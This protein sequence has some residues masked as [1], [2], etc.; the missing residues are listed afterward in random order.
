MSFVFLKLQVNGIIQNVLFSLWLF[1]CSILL[2]RFLHAVAF[3]VAIVVKNPSANAGDP[4]DMDLIP[5]SRRS[6]GGGHDKPLQYSCLENPMGRGAW[7]PTVH[8][9]AK[10][11]T[12]LSDFTFF[13][14]F[15]LSLHTLETLVLSTTLTPLD[16]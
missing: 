9:V 6:R 3:Q 16:S 11:R 12:Q 15:F 13:L 14:S 4:R 10:S 5:G 8:R 7:W 2:L 1:L